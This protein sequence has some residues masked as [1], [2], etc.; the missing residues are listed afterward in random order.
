MIYCSMD[1]GKMKKKKVIVFIGY[2]IR[3]TMNTQDGEKRQRY[4]YIKEIHSN[5]NLIPFSFGVIQRVPFDRMGSKSC[6]GEFHI[7]MNN[8]IM[9]AIKL[10]V[11]QFFGGCLFVCRMLKLL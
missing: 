9:T 8:V 7:D 5:D 11:S 1:K 3:A 6:L 10:Y 4:K 2:Q